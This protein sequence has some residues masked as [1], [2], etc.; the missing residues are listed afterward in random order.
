MAWTMDEA[1][2]RW[3]HGQGLR[4]RVAGDLTDVVA[5]TGWIRTLGGAEAYLAL[6]A[7]GRAVTVE[8]V[9]RAVAEGS[10]G[11]TPAV[12]GCI[13]LVPAR[14]AGLCLRIA[15][16]L[17]RRRTARDLERAGATADEV[18]AVGEAAL[19]ALAA[20]PL[21]TAALRQA[22]P[23]GAVRSLGEAGKKVGLT[24]TLPPALRALELGGRIV[25]APEDGRLD[26][27]R[28]RWAIPARNPLDDTPETDEAVHRALADRFCRWAGPATPDAFA[29]WSGLG[30][31]AARAACAHLDEVEVEGL[32]P[33]RIAPGD[34][35]VP[36]ADG[37]VRWLPAL[38]NLVALR[39]RSADVVDPGGH[40]VEVG[41]FGSGGPKP[42]AEVNVPLARLLFHADR[43]VGLWEVDGDRVVHALF[44][45]AP[46]PDPGPVSQLVAALGHARV[47]SVDGPKGVARRV[48]RVAAV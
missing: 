5:R 7:R 35:A 38:D 25:R 26:H 44:A 15:H 12:R 39:G 29:A 1:R 22:L 37:Q 40:A 30:K 17:S 13:Y 11:V 43:V 27:E 24:T 19:D 14:D 41:V 18:A 33:A 36:P 3:A 2:A 28:Y 16:A 20:G 8:A 23:P 6:A 48:A 10:L 45:R 46:A 31:R 34:D 42:L 4:T 47:S 9:H 32:G 21:T